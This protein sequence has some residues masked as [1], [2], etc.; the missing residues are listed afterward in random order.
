MLKDILKLKG[1]SALDK[2]QQKAVNGGWGEEACPTFCNTAEDCL[3]PDCGFQWAIC[4][5]GGICFV[6]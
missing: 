6:A 4:S 5:N 3:P 2:K 1:V